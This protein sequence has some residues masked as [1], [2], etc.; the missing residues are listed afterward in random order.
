VPL[1]EFAAYIFSLLPVL[2]H[3]KQVQTLIFYSFNI[4]FSPISTLGPS[5]LFFH[6]YWFFFGEMR[7]VFDVDQPPHPA[8]RI[9]ISR[10]ITLLSF[11]ICKACYGRTFTFTSY[12]SVFE[13][14][15]WLPYRRIEFCK[16][17]FHGSHVSHVSHASHVSRSVSVVSIRSP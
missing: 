10:I 11:C 1:L 9:R 6:C 5:S 3:I 4:H 14:I 17:V 7:P 16:C 2:D 15:S 13:V 8:T 12:F